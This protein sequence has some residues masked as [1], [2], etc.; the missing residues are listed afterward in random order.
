M[1]CQSANGMKISNKYLR[2]TSRE[3]LKGQVTALEPKRQKKKKRKKKKKKRQRRR[4]A[5]EEGKQRKLT[6]T[7]LWWWLIF[8]FFFSF[9]IIYSCRPKLA[10][11]TET[12]RNG[13]KLFPRWN[14]GVSR[15]GLHI[16]KRFSG[17][18]GQNGMV[19][20]TLATAPFHHN[21]YYGCYQYEGQSTSTTTNL[22]LLFSSPKSQ[23]P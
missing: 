11:M 14:K 12:R 18:S 2:L 5:R 20:T 19:F 21:I 15:S 4:R 7:W 16:G 13:P 17:R 22:T 23:P 3:S 10:R 6:C 9:S 1:T 8:F